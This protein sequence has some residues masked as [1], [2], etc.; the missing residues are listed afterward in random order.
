MFCQISPIG[1]V[2]VGEGAL[3]L[4]QFGPC[5]LQK[6]MPS[7]ENVFYFVKEAGAA[8]GGFV[9]RFQNLAQLFHDAFLLARQL[10]RNIHAH[11]DV[12]IAFSAVRIR[13]T[14]ALLAENLPRLRALRNFQILFGAQSW[15]ANF[16]AK[17]RLRKGNRNGA[18]KIRVA[19]LKVRM[20]FDLKEDVKVASR[21]AIGPGPPF[22]RQSQ[23]RFGI[24][25]S[26]N[27]D[28]QNF[29]ALDSSLPAA[30]RTS[31]AN[32]LPRPLAS[33]ASSRDREKS[34]LIVKLPA[35]SASLARRH[36]ASWLRP[37]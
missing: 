22:P 16:C 34:L 31:L 5:E 11:I 26:R 18:E 12:Q 33:W 2:L 19:P 7:A 20:L 25:S 8:F 10:R 4:P 32:S 36:S 24:H 17:R 9:L 30:L 35:P 28:F 27:R 29:L 1:W 21:P 14:L 37:S 15:H 6:Q 23:P 3:A 13:Q